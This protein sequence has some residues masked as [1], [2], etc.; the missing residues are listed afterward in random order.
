MSRKLG[1]LSVGAKLSLG[2]GLVLIFTVS[3]AVT[4]FNSL[5]IL[6]A[7]SEQLQ[8]ESAIRALILQA[9]ISEKDF[10]LSL[11]QQNL[12]QVRASIDV[13]SRL[14]GGANVDPGERTE[15]RKASA[16]YL[17]QFLRYS[18][19]L[20]Q[21]RSARLHMQ[22]RAKTVGDSFTGVF[23]DQMDVLN[24]QLERGGVANVEQMARLEQTGD[25][26]NKLSKLRDSELYYSLDGEERYRNDWETNMSDILASMDNL[27]LNLGGP[28][29]E[30]L[31]IARAAFKD[32][33][34]AF[35]QFVADRAQARSGDEAMTT[36]AQRIAA[37]LDQNNQRQESALAADSQNAYR[38][39]A[40]IS[41]LALG[42]GVGASLLIRHL[43][44]QP[45]RQAVQLTQR[46]AAGD[47]S[48]A[49]L[50][51]ERRDE[52]GQLLETARNM[53]G[54][55]RVLVGRIHQ[56]VNLMGGTVGSLVNVIER[57]GRGVE[58]QRLETELA[59]TAMDQMT[60][61]AK[62]VAR[63]ADEASAAVAQAHSHAREGDELVRMAGGKIDCLALEMTGCAG[64]MESLLRESASIGSVLD[65]IKAV[66]EQTNLLALN[67]A[68]EAARAGKHGRGFAVV[69]DAV[70]GLA[71][72]TQSST[73]EIESL[74]MRLRLVVQEAAERLHGSHV[75]TSETVIL[76]GQASQALTKITQAVLSIEQMNQHIA[77]AAQQQSAVADKV[78]QSMLR[79]REV[80]EGSARESLQL[81]DSTVE[82]RQV[83]EELNKAVGIFRL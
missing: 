57:S 79:V 32:Y 41:L 4:A 61:T 33:R 11:T 51:L 46:V 59:A 31:Q 6:Q 65:V 62:E 29:Q 63:N 19:S 26:F 15:M 39:L 8:S 49:L 75:L 80:A 12:E 72:R 68:I 34:E 47:L 20:R 55:L 58:Q 27:A 60:F 25:L 77:A 16:A 18:D 48:A 21:A 22:D 83:G 50:S 43:I 5:A 3:V 17:E 44:L 54:S 74:I 13:L 81:S 9:R 23:L 28:Q 42:L 2:F 69:A 1:D 82:L 73:L 64:V 67:A 24:T 37:L 45:L 71:K 53:L 70:R 30:S 7:R 76:A 38:R 36:Q 14:L 66:A 56:G 40:L 35:E 52:L 78:S 10:A